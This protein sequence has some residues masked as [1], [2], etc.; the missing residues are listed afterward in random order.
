[1]DEQ[2]VILKIVNNPTPFLQKT[3]IVAQSF[4][5]NLSNIFRGPNW[6]FEFQD[7]NHNKHFKIETVSRVDGVFWTFIPLFL[8]NASQ[9]QPFA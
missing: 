5:F 7:A 4:S 2:E 1:M 3:H 9:R 8:S 6:E